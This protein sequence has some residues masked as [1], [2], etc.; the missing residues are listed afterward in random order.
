MRIKS[1]FRILALLMLAGTTAANAQ[2][3][4]FSIDPIEIQ[5]GETKTVTVNMTNSEGLYMLQFNTMLPEELSYVPGTLVYNTDRLNP[6]QFVL[7]ESSYK[8]SGKQMIVTPIPLT[9]DKAITEGD[10]WLVKFDVKATGYSTPQVANILGYNAKVFPYEDNSTVNVS[11]FAGQVNLNVGT[12]LYGIEP[13][14]IVLN[15]G[16][17]T[18]VSVTLE[19][20]MALAGGQLLIMDA[21]GLTYSNFKKNADRFNARTGLN[22]K[23]GNGFT[24]VVM[25]AMYL[26][27][28]ENPAIKGNEGVLFTFDVTASADFT[29]QATIAIK[30]AY[31]ATTEGIDIFSQNE[32][33]AYIQSG[34]PAYDAAKAEVNSLQTA[35][36]AALTTIRTECADVATAYP[37]TEIQQAITALDAAVEE[38]YKSGKTDY[39]EV[40]T[41]AE[42]IRTDI[43]KLLSDAKAAQQAFN[44]NEVRKEANLKAYND[45]LQAIEEQQKA[46]NDAA[47]EIAANYPAGNDTEAIA[48]IQSLIDQAKADAKTALDA[49]AEEGN[50]KPVELT[51]IANAITKLLEDA[52]A[53]QQAFNDNEARKEANLKAYND[54]L[55]A[56]E[57][58]QKALNDA[59]AEIAANYPAGNDTEAIAAIQSLIDQAK[60]DAKTALDAVAEE[61]NYKPVELTAIANAITKLLEDAKAAQAAADEAARKAANEA[62]YQ[63]DIAAIDALIANYNI[64]VAQIADKYAAFRDATAEANVLNSLNSAKKAIQDAYKAVAQAGNYATPENV[65]F[66]SL[67]N[68]IA[69]LLT[70][71]QAKAEATEAERVAANEAAYQADLQSVANLQA[72][73]DAAKTELETNYAEYI[74]TAAVEAAQKAINDAKTAADKEYAAVAEAGYYKTQV[75]AS[76]I[77]AM[78][79]ALVPA[80]Q[81]AESQANEEK[82]VAANEK[83]AAEDRA[84]VEDIQAYYNTIVAEI[85]ADYAEYEDLKA[86]A[87]VQN[88]ITAALKAIDKALADVKTEGEYQSPVNIEELK[89]HVDALLQNA[90]DAKEA[91]RVAANE[92]AYQADMDLIAEMQQKLDEAKQEIQKLYPT[93]AV[94]S[95]IDAIQATIDGYTAKA[96]AEKEATADEGMY[97]RQ[98]SEIDLENI[99]TAINA[100]IEAA[101]IDGVYVDAEGNAP[102]AIYTLNGQRVSRPASGQ[103]NIFV[104]PDSTVKRYV[105]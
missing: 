57:E 98:V 86:E 30:E 42:S 16:C 52:K 14:E 105:K 83:A 69:K 58:Q 25:A 93:E 76:A 29:G 67:Q 32:P 99:E 7:D 33:T 89:S 97:E 36:N 37:G 62:A 4:T 90:K 104:Y 80:A 51:A 74:P 1:I 88:E 12:V 55:Q 85:K 31:G 28:E 44:D 73:L 40:L 94:Q 103:V 87:E 82:R 63:K 101:G 78:I 39:T 5:P 81:Q 77:E 53:A 102:I 27:T 92:A 22:T 64:T 19:N 35:L 13:A 68:D 38:A 21:P 46:L 6:E 70:D 23:Q 65:N 95:Q 45:N 15:P 72:L 50:Y 79:A 24:N 17:T 66:E 84:A 61:G 47:A 2:E 56:I 8:A 60:A 54:N 20:S 96:D 34:K 59:A 75:D 26:P 41:P 9:L 11:D 91:A 49:V 18:T 43:A 100:A 71:A 10:G 48:A 3:Y